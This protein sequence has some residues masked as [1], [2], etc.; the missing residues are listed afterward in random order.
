MGIQMKKTLLA[1]TIAADLGTVCVG[2]S[3]GSNGALAGGL[4]GALAGQALGHYTK[5]TLIGA[6]VG[7]AVGYGVRQR[8]R[9]E[10]PEK[11][12]VFAPPFV[13]RAPR[14]QQ[15]S[16]G[17]PEGELHFPLFEPEYFSN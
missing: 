13:L 7:S 1:L 15:L 2:R 14:L 4:L 5:D 11:L 12:L 3:N 8:K 9:Q 17:C 16:H 6:S 10:P